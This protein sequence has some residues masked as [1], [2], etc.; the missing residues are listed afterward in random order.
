MHFVV[1]SPC[2]VRITF[3][4][5]FRKC[6]DVI[7]KR[8][9]GGARLTLRTTREE[10]S[11]LLSVSRRCVYIYTYTDMEKT[12]SLLS[13]SLLF[14]SFPPFILRPFFF[15]LLFFLSR[16]LAFYRLLTDTLT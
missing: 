15:F 5:F 8:T 1:A 9:E 3:S 13:F 10:E 11:T 16:G 14:F 7:G 6:P 12:L 2:T 4:V